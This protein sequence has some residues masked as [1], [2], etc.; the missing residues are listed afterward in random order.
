MLL[1][2]LLDNSI[3]I[4]NRLQ[5][6]VKSQGSEEENT[7]FEQQNKIQKCINGF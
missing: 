2:M 7:F 3:T 6:S 4:N 5:N 1:L